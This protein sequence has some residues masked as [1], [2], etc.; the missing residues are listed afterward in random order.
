MKL[1]NTIVKIHDIIL[2]CSLK[3]SGYQSAWNELETVIKEE[4]DL[5]KINSIGSVSYEATKILIVLYPKYEEFLLL[6]EDYP[7]D[8][9]TLEPEEVLNLYCASL[10]SGMTSFEE[11]KEINK[12]IKQILDTNTPK[13][14][15]PTTPFD[16]TDPYGDIK[17]KKQGQ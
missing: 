8:T 7:E 14:P 4:V 9:L 13:W 5:S 3:N 10:L 11:D 12:T 16:D 15:L 1:E 17:I 2:K 6:G